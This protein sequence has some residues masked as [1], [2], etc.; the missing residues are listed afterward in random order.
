MRA[1]AKKA[2]LL[3]S[4]CSFW[5]L[6]VY[7]AKNVLSAVS[8]QMIESGQFTMETIGMLS[9]VY[10]ITYAVGQ[11]INGKLGDLVKGKYMTSSGLLC[12]GICNLLF[13]PLAERPGA[14]YVVYGA[15]GFFLSMFY[16]P[17]SK[18]IAENTEMPYTTRC[19]LAYT[20][21]S[22]LGSPMAGILAALFIWQTVFRFSAILLIAMGCICFAAFTLFER[23][24]LVEYN[25]YSR[26]KATGGVA[27]L[28]KH[29]IVK[30]TLIAAITGVVRSS[31]VFWLPT[32]LT[33]K[34]EFSPEKSAVL[35]TVATIGIS[36][37][38]FIAIFVYEKLGRNMNLTILIA[39]CSAAICF[40]GVFAFRQPAFNTA[41]MIFAILSSNCASTMLWSC[42][43][44]SLR[45]TGMVSSATGFL[46]FVSYMAAAASTKVTASMVGYIG[47][48]G[49]ILLWLSLM[50][51]GIFVALPYKKTRTAETP[52]KKA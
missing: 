51:V 21:S 31:V 41:M 50:I 8:P 11:L 2:I 35:F 10:F 22:L 48:D 23:A 28:F 52:H 27:L 29:Q 45:D 32:Y 42:Y 36:S 30:F 43:C 26:P 44:L 17:M 5:Y 47:W 6:S 1:A 39:F 15:M 25:K 33:Q 12:A 13:L 38:S 7:V 14:V 40:V 19:S 20:F 49:L 16:G 34:L 37:A 4:M 24:G 3:G 18:T 9:S 46:D